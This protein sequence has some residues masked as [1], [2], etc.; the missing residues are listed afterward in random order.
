MKAQY[1][2]EKLLQAKEQAKSEMVTAE[3]TKKRLQ[4]E[5]NQLVATIASWPLTLE[6]YIVSCDELCDYLAAR[7]VDWKSSE[8]PRE[9]IEGPFEAFPETLASSLVGSSTTGSEASAGA[10]FC[11]AEE[12]AARR[13]YELSMLVRGGGPAA[14]SSESS[15]ISSQEHGEALDAV[16]IS[17]DVSSSDSKSSTSATSC[18]VATPN[19]TPRRNSVLTSVNPQLL[20][21]LDKMMASGSKVPQTPGSVCRRTSLASC[22]TPVVASTASAIPAPSAEE[23]K[24][25]PRS[26]RS[27]L[28]QKL[29]EPELPAQP[30]A[31]FNPF[32][33]G[34]VSFLDQIKARAAKKEEANSSAA[35]T[36]APLSLMA[37]IAMRRKEE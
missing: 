7:D 21:T 26:T 32:A 34:A 2:A 20:A 6:Q 15:A 29:L 22:A 18:A 3:Q 27:K 25:V 16:A 12:D 24:S 23:E 19:K 14:P 37:Q 31:R 33:G 5:L 30:A 10:K 36:T 4:T 28:L 8:A 1:G 17:E 13:K 35:T 11:G 9:L